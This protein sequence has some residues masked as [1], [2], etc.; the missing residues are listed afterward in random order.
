MAR[1]ERRRKRRGAIIATLLSALLGA[2]AATA[3]VV[4]VLELETPDD[5]G[6]VL[7]GPADTVDPGTVIPY[8]G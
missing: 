8:G 5:Q 4:T 2:G 7:R 1:D 6:A 3:A